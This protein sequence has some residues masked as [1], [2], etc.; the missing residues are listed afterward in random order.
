MS[1]TAIAA[2]TAYRHQVALRAANGGAL[3]AAAWIAFGTGARPYTL[4][5]TALEAEFFRVPANNS[6]AGVQ[7]TVAGV[8]T[9][10]DAGAHV[11]REV[12][13]FSADGTLMG[14][15]VLTPKELEPETQLEIELVFQY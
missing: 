6:V 3:P 10:I 8:L 13:V 5:D 2:T 15:R 11:L 14:R 1:T 12:G 9:G 4:D 7:M